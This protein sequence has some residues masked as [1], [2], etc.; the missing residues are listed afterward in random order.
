[1]QHVRF[2][3]CTHKTLSFLSCWKDLGIASNRLEGCHSL[4]HD[5]GFPCR[6]TQGEYVYPL[7]TGPPRIQPR[8]FLL[9]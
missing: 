4:S 8:T 1:M 6:R 9:F 2:C 3:R 5:D 7:Q